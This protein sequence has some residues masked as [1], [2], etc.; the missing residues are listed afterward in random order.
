VILREVSWEDP[1]GVALRAAQRAEI[2]ERYG[3]DDSEP[4]PA[5]TAED[6]TLFVVAFD[7][8]D[9]P[10]ACGG[11]RR[12]DERH[13]EIKRMFARPDRRG[14]GV[15]TAVLR[16]LEELGRSRLGWSRLVLETGDQQPDAVRFYEREGYTRIPNFGYYVGSPYSVC[17]E[18]LLH[19]VGA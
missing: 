16:E 14:S 3:R 8:D 18:K 15:A 1:A 2:S 12:I 11:L 5:P 17:Y 6:I 4:G 13:G 10:V 7:D 9:T 19:R